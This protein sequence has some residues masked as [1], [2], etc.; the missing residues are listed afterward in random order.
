MQR[1]HLE[2]RTPSQVVTGGAATLS[3]LYSGIP[4]FQGAFNTCGATNI[5]LPLGVGTVDIV[6][7]ACPT[8]AGKVGG[9]TLN[10]TVAIPPG[11]PPGGYEVI[12]NAADQETKPAYCAD[13]QFTIGSDGSLTWGKPAAPASLRGAA[14]DSKAAKTAAVQ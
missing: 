8:V 13:A 1:P 4:L 10:V 5:S 11:V 3:V 6:S 9:M 14:V 12:L 2:L 7:L